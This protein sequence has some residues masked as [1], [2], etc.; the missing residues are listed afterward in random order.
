MFLLTPGFFKKI[1]LQVLPTFLAFFW[2]SNK[3]K[4]FPSACTSCLWSLK[5]YRISGVLY[6]L[7]ELANI[8][9]SWQNWKFRKIINHI[10]LAASITCKVQTLD[11]SDLDTRISLKILPLLILDIAICTS[12]HLHITCQGETHAPPSPRNKTMFK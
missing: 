6:Q 9:I 10:L 11:T 1:C 5:R 4:K 2:K 3:N 8:N 12:N 7:G